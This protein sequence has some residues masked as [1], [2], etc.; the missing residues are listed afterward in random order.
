MIDGLA[1]CL[2]G[3]IANAASYGVPVLYRKVVGATGDRILDGDETLTAPLVDAAR[4]LVRQGA[5]GITSNCG[6]AALYQP[7]L[8]GAVSVPVF[9]SSL[10][11]VP[12]VAATLPVNRKV[13]ILTYDAAHLGPR[14]FRAVGWDPSHLPV[15]VA[16]VRGLPAWE[17]LSKPEGEIDPEAMWADLRRVAE[18]LCRREPS[19]A[20]LVLECTAMCP[21]APAL[22]AA[23]RRPVFDLNSLIHYMLRA[24][25][26]PAYEGI[27]APP[28]AAGLSVAT[29]RAGA[30]LECLIP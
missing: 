20:A 19:V 24:L 2:P 13:G 22:Q 27:I 18:E 6:F 15:A 11:Q 5:Q 7:A 29:V 17:M 25:R 14:H 9:V 26:Y 1:T 23:L 12:Q 4:D 30:S 21:F 28:A 3:S 8:A 10:L 16:G